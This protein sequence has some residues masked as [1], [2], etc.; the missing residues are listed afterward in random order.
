MEE[1]SV[2]IHFQCLAVLRVLSVTSE[3]CLS[4]TK[5]WKALFICLW[6]L[7]EIIMQVSPQQFET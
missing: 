5:S 1:K 2:L 6:G 7:S 3:G 4:S